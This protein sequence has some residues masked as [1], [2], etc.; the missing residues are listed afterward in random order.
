MAIKRLK[1]RK[2]NY[3]PFHSMTKTVNTEDSFVWGWRDMRN[4]FMTV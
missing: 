1:E 4:A 3:F 2:R